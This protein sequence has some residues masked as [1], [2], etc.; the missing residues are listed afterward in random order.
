[1]KISF[2]SPINIK[3][4]FAIKLEFNSIVNY[5]L[6]MARLHIV[7][8]C[9]IFASTISFMECSIEAFNSNY[10]VA[11]SEADLL[12]DNLETNWQ[13]LIKQEKFDEKSQRYQLLYQ[14]G[15]RIDGE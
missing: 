12:S 10:Q 5:F 14:F 13:P 4:N 8:L 11:Q 9:L 15:Q 1:M 6:K 2:I 7:V 3:I